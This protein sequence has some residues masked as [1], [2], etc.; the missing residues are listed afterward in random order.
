M[1]GYTTVIEAAGEP[2]AFTDAQLDHFAVELESCNLTVL[3]AE[4]HSLYGAVLS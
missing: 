1:A 4:N 2:N 3:S